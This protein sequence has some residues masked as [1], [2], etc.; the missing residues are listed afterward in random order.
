MKK[1]LLAGLMAALIAP[2]AHA[3]HAMSGQPA[4]GAPTPGVAN[5]GGT[6]LAKGAPR[7]VNP[8]ALPGSRA[9]PTQ[10]APAGKN[11]A[12]M[13]PTEALFDAINR[14]DLP[15]AKESVNRGADLNGVNVLGLSPIELAV[16]LGRNEISFYLLSLRGGIAGSS[17]PGPDAPPK[18]P[19][20][21]ERQ[22]AEREARPERVAKTRSAAVDN[23]PVAPRTA[24]LFAG[25]GGSP[26][27]Q[28]GFLG[29]GANR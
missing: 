25:D 9:E 15:A 26:N 21:A 23:R 16:D 5:P 8:P 27:P 12:D 14:G 3:Q 28:A 10:V 13:P 11:T 7:V 20:R 24:R 17:P 6:P 22:A 18:P 19:T 2:A 1:L 29:F 4:P